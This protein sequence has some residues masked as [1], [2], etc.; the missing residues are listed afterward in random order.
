MGKTAT[1]KSLNKRLQLDLTD[2]MRELVSELADDTGA[3][4]RAEVVRNAISVYA[5]LVGEF[6][7]GGEIEIIHRK[8]RSKAVSR[9][10]LLLPFARKTN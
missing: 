4:T 8:S 5:A 7:K 1:T 3:S 6:N 2:E 9:Y 10:R